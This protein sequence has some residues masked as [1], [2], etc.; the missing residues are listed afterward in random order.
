MK[1]AAQ[2]S[3][4]TRR[5][6]R[7]A[8]SAYEI[9]VH[10]MIADTLRLSLSAGWIWWHTPNGGLRNKVEAAKMVRMGVLPGVSDFLL[11]GPPAGRLHALELKRQGV[12]PTDEQDQFLALL[13]AAGGIADWVDNYDDALNVLRGW[14]A[15]RARL[16]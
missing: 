16:A 13:R 2:L 12:K 5:P 14:G 8:P 15:V 7:R 11:V 9:A 3:L 4:F 6:A 1:G 10:C